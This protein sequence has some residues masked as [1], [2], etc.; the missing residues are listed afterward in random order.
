MLL[1][2]DRAGRHCARDIALA[3]NP[4]PIFRPSY[5]AALPFYAS[6]FDAIERVGLYLEERCL[7]H[8]LWP[9]CYDAIVDTVCR[10]WQCVTG[11]AG[12][13]KSLCSMDCAQGAV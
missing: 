8:R 5:A 10:A 9:D 1:L 7:S 4:T 2:A 12:R 6:E 3:A 11:G 13:T